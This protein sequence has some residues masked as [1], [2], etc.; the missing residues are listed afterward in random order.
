MKRV[1]VNQSSYIPWKGYFD[2]IHDADLFV[3]YDDVQFTV[4]DWRSRNRIKTPQGAIWLTV[5]VGSDRNRLVC[6]V[7]ITDA[8][9]QKRHFE[10]LRHSYSRAPYFRDYEPFLRE[11]YLERRWN[12]LSAL[13]QFLIRRIA[14][15]FLGIRTLFAQSTEFNAPG[16]KADRILA[17]AKAAGATTYL[18][19]PA[20]K[21]YLDPAAF[22]AAGIELQWKEYPAYP[23]YPQLHPPFDHAVTVLDLLFHVGPAA[24]WYIWGWREGSPRPDDSLG[25]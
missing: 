12:N 10:S 11:V 15:E 4:R 17:L 6:D 7:V 14:E 24:P 22:S 23:E 13:N 19:G 3:F 2:L 25:Q 21:A 16:R 9:W 20:A 18:S 8:G 5:P 1:V